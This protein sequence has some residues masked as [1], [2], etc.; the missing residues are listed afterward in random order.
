MKI[1]VS[2]KYF[3]VLVLGILSGTSSASAT[4][5]IEVLEPPSTP[6]NAY[7]GTF[8]ITPSESTWAFGVGNDDIQD[9]SISGIASSMD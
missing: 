6:G 1:Q 2:P 5:I 4:S 7:T 8:L 9:T 3:V